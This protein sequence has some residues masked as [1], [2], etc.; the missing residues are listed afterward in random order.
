[1]VN[2]QFKSRFL[3]LEQ[4]AQTQRTFPSAFFCCF[5]L[6]FFGF[7]FGH[8]SNDLNINSPF[9]LHKELSKDFINKNFLDTNILYYIL[10]KKSKITKNYLNLKENIV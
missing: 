6:Q 10:H 4:E 3:V 8:T 2:H 9:A 1:M 7:P 5:P